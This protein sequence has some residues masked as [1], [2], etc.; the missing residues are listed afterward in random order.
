MTAHV[1]LML[2]R[3]GFLA[4]QR[5]SEAVRADFL[6]M[7]ATSVLMVR[8]L[9]D[10]DLSEISIIFNTCPIRE[11]PIRGAS[12]NIAFLPE[13]SA[14]M[15]ESVSPRYII[16]R[17]NSFQNIGT[18]LE[19]AQGRFIDVLETVCQEADM[20][21]SEHIS[22]GASR[23]VVYRLDDPQ[24]N[25]RASAVALANPGFESALTLAFD[26]DGATIDGWRECPG[27]TR[28]TT[29]LPR[30]G[31]H[32]L[33]MEGSGTARTCA[34]TS[35]PVKAGTLY[36]LVAWARGYSGN[37]P[38]SSGI[39][40][41]TWLD[42]AAQPV[43]VDSQAV[44]VGTNFRWTEVAQTISAPV[45]ATLARVELQVSA[46]TPSR[47]FVFYDSVEMYGLDVGI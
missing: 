16:V 40:Q 20:C 43:S 10:A 19:E 32:A 2:P 8:E 47:S 21:Y 37:D 44:D 36:R 17:L 18:N 11:W 35:A 34:S 25:P 22:A 41:V 27:N 46:Q 1:S 39:V 26:V 9:S 5:W 23:V 12:V 6:D 30:S 3:Y 4:T 15:I 28:V 7:E 38:V 24:R 45:G 31:K 33:R 13:I 29:D 42:L 14:T